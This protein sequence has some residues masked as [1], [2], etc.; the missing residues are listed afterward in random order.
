M[1]KITASSRDYQ[2]E[3]NEV[4][5]FWALD[6]IRAFNSRP[7]WARWL[8][9]TLIGEKARYELEG[10]ADQLDLAGY[11]VH[12]ALRPAR[13]PAVRLKPKKTRIR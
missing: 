7:W 5:V 9:E 6:F 11:D 8:A 2:E 13:K 10:L 12:D 4:V 1:N 3:H